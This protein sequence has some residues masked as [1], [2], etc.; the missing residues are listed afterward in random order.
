[1]EGHPA[2]SL[3]KSSVMNG[4]DIRM[5]KS[6]RRSRFPE[7]PLH[8]SRAWIGLLEDLECDIAVESGIVRQKNVS[9]STVSQPLAQ[10]EPPQ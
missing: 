5:I 6:C 10:L 2:L 4:D 8:H 1:M 9:E 7:K 3:V